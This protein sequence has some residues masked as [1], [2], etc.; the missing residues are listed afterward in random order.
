MLFLTIFTYVAL[1]GFVVLS[2]YKA[3]QYAKMPM[4]SR[5]EL[6]PVPKEA[7][8]IGEEERGHYGGSFYEEYEW[9]KKP[10][11]VSHLSE[12]IDM[13]KEMLFIKILFV[14]NQRQWWLCYAMHLGIYVLFAWTACLF[15]GAVGQLVG[16]TVNA[17]TGG[18]GTILYYIT[19]LLGISG[20]ILVAVGSI[21]MV[22]KRKKDAVL[23]KYTNPQDYFNL[24]FIFAVAVSGLVVWVTDPFFNYGREIFKALLTFSPIEPSIANETAL[25]VH[26]VLLGLLLLYIPMTKMS[27]YVGKYFVFHEVIWSNDP[28]L[29]GTKTG[30]KVRKALQYKPKRTWSAPHISVDPRNDEAK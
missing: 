22:L 30:E 1:I 4:H 14:N 5:F 11:K 15:L 23:R 10:R 21:G 8:G 26:I 19:F 20:A 3:Y 6:Y 9:Y 12:I 17:T 29:K 16:F 18:W 13:L 27:H 28:N 25:A 2:A 24:L 7:G